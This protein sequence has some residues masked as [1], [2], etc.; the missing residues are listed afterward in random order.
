LLLSG[1]LSSKSLYF[2]FNDA[3]FLFKSQA[4][5]LSSCFLFLSKAFFLSFFFKANYLS[6][7]RIEQ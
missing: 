3:G 4:F 5:S 7:L 1:F 6:L 2:F